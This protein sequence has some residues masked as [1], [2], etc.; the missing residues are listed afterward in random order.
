MENGEIGNKP[1]KQEISDK[2]EKMWIN[3]LKELKYPLMIILPFLILQ[4]IM[5]SQFRQLPSPLYGGDG[6]WH[7]GEALMIYNGGL[8][9][10]NLQVSGEYAYY[11]WLNQLLVAFMAKLFAMDVHTA[12]I[13]FPAVLTVMVGI[14]S[15]FLGKEFFG[16]RKFSLA[17]CLL[18]LT[19]GF[20]LIDP[21]RILGDIVLSMAFMLFLARALK[22]G[23]LSDRLAAGLLLGLA[24]LTHVI[25]FPALASFTFVLF[26]YR[27]FLS[28]IHVGFSP[29]DS[30]LSV[31]FEERKK[32]T[33]D[34]I[35]EF[36]PV[37]LI[38]FLI[39]LLF[40]WPILFVY[41]GEI[42]NPL[43]EYTEPDLSSY[44]FQVLTETLGGTF[45][46]FSS[47][48]L[49]AL[50]ILTLFGAYVA[51]MSRK[52]F[53]CQFVFILLLSSLLT[54]FHYL[55]TIPVSGKALIPLYFYSFLMRVCVP[56]LFMIAAFSVYEKLSGKA[57][58][59]M[60]A[61]LFLFLIVNAF[62]T[63]SA[64][65]N[66][67]WAKNGRSEPTPVYNEI[68]DWIS[69]NTERTDVFLS[70]EELSFAVNSISTRNV[71]I[72][73]R[74]HFSP[75]LDIDRRIA[76]ASIILYGNNTQKADEL[77]G[78]YGLKYVYWD[79]NWA[80]FMQMETHLTSTEFERY[81]TEN[82][83]PFQKGNGYLDPAW[84]SYH[85]KYDVLVVLPEDETPWSSNLQSR[86]VLEKAFYYQN[87]EFARIY[88]IE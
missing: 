35:L 14:I 37:I 13:Y 87:Q 22:S 3:P 45:L 86:L 71:L 79:A 76:D 54:G 57:K 21:M 65:Y 31:S 51:A 43:Q 64:A 58:K 36:L 62:S 52:D 49:I 50:S 77:I 6:Y 61:V 56:L 84:S 10:E 68:A 27:T 1:V 34:G 55:I 83:V 17:F 24:G 33:K 70:H 4:L 16:N 80:H 73:R 38:G 25:A 7:S 30:K 5:L 18:S 15:Y 63:M 85:P 67:T 88:R 29:E 53:H 32:T 19:S 20:T 40:F 75:Y 39:S 42:K 46:N 26:L 82:G 60:L 2:N 72:S 66:D 11:G 41:H 8:P 74:T 9:W 78:K 44:G 12:Y 48:V 69:K 59:A 47:P 23:K 28:H 81:L